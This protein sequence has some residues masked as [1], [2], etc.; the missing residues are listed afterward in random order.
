MVEHPEDLKRDVT[1]IKFLIH[2]LR[3]ES[4]INEVIHFHATVNTDLEIHNVEQAQAFHSEDL[5]ELKRK[6]VAQRK[7]LQ[8]YSNAVKS[9]SPNETILAAGRE[10]VQTIYNICELILDPR[11]GRVDTFLSFLP[12]KSRSVRTYPHYLNCIRWIGGVY[13]RIHYF[14]KEKDNNDL[15][16]KFDI[17]GELRD[18]VRN[19]VYGYVTE[20]SSARVE[21]RLDRL[22]PAILGG[23]RYR[24]RRMFFNL[25]MNAVDAMSHKKVG[26][27]TISDV[28]DADSVILRVRDNGSGIPPEKIEQLMTDKKSLDGELHSLGFVFVRQTVAEF[29][30][31]L[32]IESLVDKGTTISIS[33]PRLVGAVATP[34]RL[35]ASE[36]ADLVQRIDKAR[37]EER[38]AYLKKT[39]KS[40]DEHDTCGETIY[41]DYLVSDAEFPGAIFAIAVTEDNRIDLF[42]HRSYERHWNITHED[43]SPMLFEATVRGRI[44]EE[45]DKTPALILKSPQSVQEYFEFR[46]VPDEDRTLEKYVAMVHDEFIRIARTVIDT[47][48]S[49]DIGVHVTD[50]KK[51][52][53]KHEELAEQEPFPLE[54]LARLN[55]NSEHSP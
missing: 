54:T 39:A 18:F 22:D 52:F 42:T 37:L 17:A 24:F 38:A 49:P 33:L 50:L 21:I 1:E 41:G 4:F 31:S 32:S 45:E 40:S 2:D 10:Y 30:G 27:L 55:Q 51:F 35:M 28:V 44:E 43:L 34:R 8:R 25:V 14:M 19:V 48:M 47:G 7:A 13:Y 36:E 12:E 26:V 15:Y 53:P 3:V 9:F 6:A 20:K 11:W 5:Q 29:N 46:G 16:E 23:N